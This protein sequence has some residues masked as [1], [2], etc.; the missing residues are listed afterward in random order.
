V[1]HDEEEGDDDGDDA[2]RGGENEAEV[3]EGE[4]LP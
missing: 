3:V 2:K 4:A 1:A